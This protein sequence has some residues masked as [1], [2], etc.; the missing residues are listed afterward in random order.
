MGIELNEN[1]VSGET[2]ASW[3]PIELSKLVKIQSGKSPSKFDLNNVGKG[4][5]FFKVNDLNFTNKYLERANLYFENNDVSL[6]KKG[7]IVF[8]KRGAAIFTNKIAILNKDGYFDTNIMGLAVNEN[9][10]NSEYL[11]YYLKEIRLDQLADTS[12]VPQINNKHINPLRVLVPTIEEQKKIASILSSV[13]KQIERTDQLIEKSKELKKGLIQKLLTIG[14]GHIEFKQTDIGEIPINWE[15]TNLNE[16]AYLRKEKFDP[17][18]TQD[19]QKYIGL[20]H[21]DSDS[22]KV[23]GFGSSKETKSLKSN[24]KI[25]DILFGKL[26]PY[27]KK[28]WLATFEGVCSTEILVIVPNINSSYLYYL[29]QQE[30]FIEFTS[31]KAYGTKMPRASWA[32]MEEYKFAVPPIEEQQKIASILLSVDEQ[33]EQ[34]SERK[35]GLVS[36]KKGLMQ[37]LLTG[38]IRVKV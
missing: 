28:Y 23:N 5:P 20:E 14:V 27:L 12:S 33:I 36:L 22:G 6:M 32:K 34:Y 38:K 16:L 21:I 7:T 4:I 1:I 2:T 10:I 37:K 11:F 31:H 30:N 3:E 26:R 18:N 35:E 29:I 24:F 19:D 13:D 8:P 25:G 9:I 17:K 15:V